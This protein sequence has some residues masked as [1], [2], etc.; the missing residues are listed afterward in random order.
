M[1]ER[2]VRLNLVLFL[3]ALLLLSTISLQSEPPM[4]PSA[5]DEQ[6]NGT[7]VVILTPAQEVALQ[8]VVGRSSSTNWVQ[9]ATPASGST[10]DVNNINGVE[11][12]SLVM[13][14]TNTNIIVGGTLIG[15]V[16]FGSVMPSYQSSQRA[17]IG[18]LSKAG[19]WDW[20]TVTG[21]IQGHA[22][23]SQFGS[24][25]VASN[26][27]IW[28][29]GIFWGEI[30]W[31]TDF[32][33]SD[34]GSIDGFVATMSS[35][36][37]WY[38]GNSMHGISNDDTVHGI[39][40][41]SNDDAYVVGSF[42]DHVYFD[43]TSYN[44]QNGQDGFIS[45][46]NKTNGTYEW[47]E[48]VGGSQDD[49]ITAIAMDSN[50]QLFV[51]GYYSGNINFGLT[52]LANTGYYSVFVAEINTLGVWQW[53]NEAKAVFGGII[54]YDIEIDS[55]GIYIGG[56]VVGKI[57]LDGVTW[58]S[59]GTVQ[60]V[61]VAKLSMSGTWIW[62]TNSSGHTQHLNDLAI[63]PLGGVAAVGW[64]DMDSPNYANVT[65]GS[66][67]FT[68]I[69]PFATF[70]AGV[71]PTGQWLWA[72]VGGG[73][74]FDSANSALFT[75]VG[76]LVTAGKYCVNLDIG[77]CTA[78]I[79]TTNYS[80]D[81]IYYSSGF[82]WSLNVDSDTDSIMDLSDNCPLDYNPNQENTDQDL[83][84][85]ACDSDMDGDGRD[86]SQDDCTNGPAV[87]WD[88]FDW[89]IDSDA[90]GCRDSDEDDDDDSDGVLDIDDSCSTLLT[91]KNWTANDAN[92][93][94]R[95]GCHDLIE[96]D[97]DDGDGVDDSVDDCAF[98]PHDRYWVSSP[99]TDYDGDGCRDE[100]EEETDR[101][102]D[103]VL[104]LDDS[105]MTGQ[106][107][108]TSGAANDHD[109]DGCRD[110][111]EDDDDDGDG[112]IDFY[113]DCTPMA[114]NW[115]SSGEQD[116][117]NDGCRDV[118]EDDDDDGDGINDDV[119]TCPRGSI[120]WTSGNITDNDGDG[121]RD[122]GEDL[123]DDGDLI[124]DLEDD[125]SKG[126]TGWISTSDIDADRDGCRDADEDWDDDGDGLWEFD[127]QGN[128]IDHCPGTPL[129]QIQFIDNFGC[130]PS[131]AD[132]D[133]DG[134]QNADDE[135]P[136]EAPPEGMDRDEN[137]CTDDFDQDG[138]KDD[139]DAFPNDSTQTIDSDG[140]GFGDNLGGTNPD[141]CPNT[142]TQWIENI[143]SY[144]CAWEE[145][146]DDEDTLL[147]GY[148]DCPDTP[149][150]EIDDIDNSGC[151]ISER[152]IDGDGTVD[153]DDQCPETKEG[154]EMVES[155]CSKEQLSYSSG[156]DSS[157]IN[158]LVVG[159]FA[160]VVM[161][162]AGGGAAFFLLNRDD[163]D[164]DDVEGHT[165]AATAFESL[166]EPSTE[167]ATDTS[168]QSVSDDSGITVDEDGTEWWEDEAGVWWYRSV[169]MD[170]WAIFER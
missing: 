148:D 156:Q 112:I 132:D 136:S 30:E 100:G 119:D 69:P 61:F 31:G 118:D 113:D 164:E 153:A 10:N 70:F 20:V 43:N 34:G 54:P 45:K 72:E 109:G 32:D 96:D 9:T 98:A 62:A 150:D 37:T 26:G 99:S 144:G 75:G 51:T 105:C 6:Q 104:D 29:T 65:F 12:D 145:S 135:C 120:G 49:N 21:L 38:W 169:S 15:S 155:G 170:D 71:S 103:G 58:W 114:T 129:L 163:G 106:L 17:F 74:L 141:A 28:V 77:G 82:V 157:G 122:A 79:G 57:D 55:S 81:S 149:S 110:V 86:N 5:D 33:I 130:S 41:D 7:G 167:V 23:G 39:V 146:D 8:L 166:E 140:D 44:I 67:N 14:H 53:A 66:F 102:N 94:D 111:D 52:T 161:I 73:I 24:V 92:D 13:D 133:G 125:C 126:I 168:T 108:W 42:S 11:I 160:L 78:H 101:D 139:V 138:V 134:I 115:D 3:S 84:G 159:L 97:D 18:S 151:G 88:S 91:H 89:T 93:Y 87:N 64:F 59:N 76:E 95:D 117:D 165:E 127:L 16:Q 116:L 137:G 25:A 22:G 56:D 4:V 147:N 36:G 46:V 27:T 60:N 123:D 90:D 85:N 1:S 162:V 48:I 19:V 47:V 80:S 2:T 158:I 152:D 124:P 83:L 40:L 107:N 63:N 154:A 50:G 128:V 68:E 121:C 143:S 142:P 35:S 131:Q